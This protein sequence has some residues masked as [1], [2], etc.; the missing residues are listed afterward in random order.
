M[1]SEKME[2]L[3]FQRKLKLER[4]IR[5]LQRELGEIEEALKEARK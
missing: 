4:K 5:N 1:N 3:L 2:I